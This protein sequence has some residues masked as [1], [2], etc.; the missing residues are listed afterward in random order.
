MPKVA[1]EAALWLSGTSVLFGAICASLFN[2]KIVALIKQGVSDPQIQSDVLIPLALVFGLSGCAVALVRIIFALAQERMAGKKQLSVV[3]AQRGTVITET[4]IILPVFFL[5]TFGLA[6]MAINAMAG[7]LTTLASYEVARSLAVWAPEE[8]NRATQSQIR[9]RAKTV[10]AG[11]IAPV[12]PMLRSGSCNTAG[13]SVES[14][15]RG[16]RRT[17]L[18][19]G[20]RPEGSISDVTGALDTATFAER[21]PTKLRL[22]YCNIDVTWD[23][24]ENRNTETP[25]LGRVKATVRYYHPTTMPMVG[26]VF[27]S[28]NPGGR[29][30]TR[31][32]SNFNKVYTMGTHLTPNI[33]P[34]YADPNYPWYNVR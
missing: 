19:T 3:R 22:A 31:N 1:V 4:L 24:P 33:Y 5:L 7:L 34:P 23:G 6:Q 8:G 12:V 16:M 17:G 20:F 9:D 18:S 10:A 25:D 28:A 14:M 21:G 11:V 30:T 13:T 27:R 26:P 29:W 2:E 15:V 32:V